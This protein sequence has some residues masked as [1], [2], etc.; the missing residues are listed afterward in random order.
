MRYSSISDR[1]HAMSQK[2]FY[3]PRGGRNHSSSSSSSISPTPLE[4]DPTN[5]TTSGQAPVQSGSKPPRLQW[6]EQR[7]LSVIDPSPQHI[8]SSDSVWDQ[9][10][11]SPNNGGVGSRAPLSP[12]TSYSPSP[13]C[14]PH[15]PS[16]LTFV[17]AY[18]SPLLQ[19]QVQVPSHIQ[20]PQP[21]EPPP[22][23]KRRVAS[24]PFS[25]T[26]TAPGSN[27]RFYNFNDRTRSTAVGS[28]GSMLITF[29]LE[30]GSKMPNDSSASAPMSPSTGGSSLPPSTSQQSPPASLLPD[31]FD[32]GP[33]ELPPRPYSRTTEMTSPS[34]GG[35]ANQASSRDGAGET[36]KPRRRKPNLPD[37][38]MDYLPTLEGRLCKIELGVRD[39]INYRQQRAIENSI[40]PP[41]RR[42]HGDPCVDSRPFPHLPT[43][44]RST[45]PSQA[46][47]L[48]HAQY[49]TQQGWY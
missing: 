35:G 24:E 20:S 21:D 16:P 8:S 34:D 42:A 10:Y 11:L 25:G 2:A 3:S 44:S 48:S 7:Q 13:L 32:H 22:L 19:G 27:R 31:D 18:P 6:P 41:P 37:D 36:N 23:K 39:Y 47:A 49:F 12:N 1:G 45:L 38:V 30:N 15:S 17:S 28:S 40:L 46:Q 43:A 26:R 14:Q 29:P 4:H 33:T 5:L 9:R